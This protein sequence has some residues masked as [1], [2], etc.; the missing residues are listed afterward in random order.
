MAS[1]K[2]I[3]PLH[4]VE[5]A[6]MSSMLQGAVLVGR[7]AGLKC[8]GRA[9]GEVAIVI[10]IVVLVQAHPSLVSACWLDAQRFSAS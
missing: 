9:G 3:E 6:F 4:L 5:D 8:A 7:A 2:W 10:D 1:D